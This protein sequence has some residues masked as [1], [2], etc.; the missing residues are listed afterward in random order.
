MLEHILEV[1]HL[2]SNEVSIKKETTLKLPRAKSKNVAS[3][4]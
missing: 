4:T 1:Q 2:E 3:M